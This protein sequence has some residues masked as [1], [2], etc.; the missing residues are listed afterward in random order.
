THAGM[1]LEAQIAA[2]ISQ[3]LIRIS[4]GIEDA[5]DIIADLAQALA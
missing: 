3:S 1:E 4:V 5:D 2:G